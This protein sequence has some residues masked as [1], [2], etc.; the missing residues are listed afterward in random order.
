MFIIT[1][2]ISIFT[3]HPVTK[4]NNEQGLFKLSIYIFIRMSKKV[5]FFIFIQ[6]VWDIFLFF[7]NSL[8]HGP[9]KIHHKRELQEKIVNIVRNKTNHIFIY[10]P[11]L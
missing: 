11:C 7:Y 3:A 4:G 5:R 1:F 8:S 9:K 10:L 2:Q 6:D